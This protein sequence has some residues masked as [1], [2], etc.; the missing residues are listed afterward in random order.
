MLPEM[1]CFWVGALNVPLSHVRIGLCF[2]GLSFIPLHSFS[3]PLGFLSRHSLFGTPF[4][5]ELRGLPGLPRPAR[6][7]AL[8]VQKAA[9]CGYAR[10]SLAAYTVRPCDGRAFVKAREEDEAAVDLNA[11]PVARKA[12]V[13]ARHTRR[14]S[15]QLQPSARRQ[16]PSTRRQRLG[17]S[18]TC[19]YGCRC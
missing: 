8:A 13:S 2:P 19:L 18:R 16:R 5:L 7:S 6:S 15:P 10:R 11:V 4:Q 1:S 17:P 14:A 9:R 12:S 3:S